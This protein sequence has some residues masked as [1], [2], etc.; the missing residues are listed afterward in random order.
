[1]ILGIDT[2]GPACSVALTK[3]GALI[4]EIVMKH[5]QIAPSD[6]TIIEKMS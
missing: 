1:M 5:A 3:D 6:I 2:S 4:Q